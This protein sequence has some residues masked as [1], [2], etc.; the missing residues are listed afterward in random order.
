MPR[1]WPH[2]GHEMLCGS[3]KEDQEYSSLPSPGP[4]KDQMLQKPWLKELWYGQKGPGGGKLGS[5]CISWP[6]KQPSFAGS[7][8][9]IQKGNDGLMPEVSPGCC[10][11]A[12]VVCSLLFFQQ[13]L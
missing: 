2:L 7:L 10:I 1:I 13:Y 5:S 3:L 11:L 9:H 4:G 6:S 8:P 12:P